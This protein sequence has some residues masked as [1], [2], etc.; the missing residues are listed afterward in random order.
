MIRTVTYEDSLV[1]NDTF[2]DEQQKSSDENKAPLQ[3][4]LYDDEA[5]TS[6]SLCTTSN[7]ESPSRSTSDSNFPRSAD[8]SKNG[9][10]S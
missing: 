2:D 8:T 7:Y 6:T 4:S 9:E 1:R 3:G 5:T 10:S